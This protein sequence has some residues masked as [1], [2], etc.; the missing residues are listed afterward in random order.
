[1]DTCQR[2]WNLHSFR[3]VFT[4]GHCAWLIIIITWGETI[5]R[6]SCCTCTWSRGEKSYQMVPQTF[7]KAT[8]LCSS[9]LVCYLSTSD[10]RKYRAALIQNSASGRSVYKICACCGD[11]E[12][13]GA[14]DIRQH[15][16]TAEWKTFSEKSGNQNWKIETPEKVCRVLQAWEKKKENFS[17]PLPNMWCGPLLGRLLWAVSHE[18]HLLR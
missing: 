15:S 7:Q 1:M 18:A 11:A 16:S 3:S 2:K 4:D 5:W 6:T 13:N 14:T 9:Q 10:G 17:V 12:C 8:Y